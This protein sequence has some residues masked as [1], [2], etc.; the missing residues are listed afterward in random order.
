ML[1]NVISDLK[2]KLSPGPGEVNFS[3]GITTFEAR[4]EKYFI[5]LLDKIRQ[6]DRETE[7]V[8]AVNGEHKKSFSERFRKNILEFTAAKE[9]VFPVMF[10]HFRGLAKLWNTL[11]VHASH[12]NILI[13]NDD[14][15]IENE[16]ALSRVKKEI[17]KNGGKSFVINDSWSHYV[18]NKKE[19]DE[20]GYFDERLLGIGEEDGD[21]C[22]RY[23]ELYGR[24]VKKVS[25]PGFKNY[26]QDTM[27]EMPSNI[28][29]RPGMKYSAFNR[30]YIEGKY[31]E[32]PGGK[33]GMFDK[34][35]KMKDPGER[36]YPHER[37]YLKNRDKL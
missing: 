30:R 29:C 14:I 3:I 18:I 8:V 37:F 11:I 35:V 6:Y 27:S 24:P 13:L 33:K 2:L 15:M 36:Q 10:P 7:I 22:W 16:R 4:F 34:P 26:A 28:E 5:P 12:E 20:V 25:I 1:R 23:I 19:I 31:A 17:Q 9:N 21:L 32:D